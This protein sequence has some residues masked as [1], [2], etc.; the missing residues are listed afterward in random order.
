MLLS[1]FTY[2]REVDYAQT[3]HKAQAWT[4]K[5]GDDVAAARKFT[6]YRSATERAE[7]GVSVRVGGG[8]ST[9]TAV[10]VQLSISKSE[11]RN[12]Y[13]LK[14]FTYGNDVGVMAVII[15]KL[16]SD[17]KIIMTNVAED[18]QSSLEKGIPLPFIDCLD[19]RLADAVLGN[20]QYDHISAILSKFRNAAFV[21]EKSNDGRVVLKAPETTADGIVINDT[22]SNQ[23]R[24]RLHNSK[25]QEM[26]SK[27]FSMDDDAA[28]K[29]YLD[30]SGFFGYVVAR[31]D[32]DLIQDGYQDWK[33][34]YQVPFPRIVDIDEL[35]SD[36]IDKAIPP[37][38]TNPTRQQWLKA[39][40]KQ[41]RKDFYQNDPDG[42]AMLLDYLK[43]VSLAGS[44][45][46][47]IFHNNTLEMVHDEEQ[48]ARVNNYF[49]S[50]GVVD[51]EAPLSKVEGKA[52][53]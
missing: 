23:L 29:K 6:A 40:S 41:E 5:D 14:N 4:A 35:L 8:I 48:I 44:I 52:E 20:Q 36:P 34:T 21:I 24:G 28:P 1:V 43:V 30:R 25:G 45:N 3:R 46:G 10:N 16:F 17:N 42:K 12:D 9:G 51:I 47:V 15:A 22:I 27:A 19:P 37:S 39:A 18:V 26:Y 32:D 50:S 38:P 7:T 53:G 33:R 2:K 31:Y 13:E 49:I 11:E